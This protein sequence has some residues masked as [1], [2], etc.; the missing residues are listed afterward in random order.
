MRSRELRQRQRAGGEQ[1]AERLPFHQK[2]VRESRVEPST[3]SG[4][5]YGMVPTS[6]PARVTSAR[7]AA[8]VE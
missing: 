3:C 5:M 8:S 1:L 4:D 6:M 2:S 7:V